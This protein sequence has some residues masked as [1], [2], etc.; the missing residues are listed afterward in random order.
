M[1][2]ARMIALLIGF[3]AVYALQFMVGWPWYIAVPAAVVCYTVVRF[4]GEAM[5]A[6]RG[7]PA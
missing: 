2:A 7:P 5:I 3:A 1:S 6:R 4:A